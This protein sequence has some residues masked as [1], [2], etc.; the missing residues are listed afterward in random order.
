MLDWLDGVEVKWFAWAAEH[1][2]TSI[3][4]K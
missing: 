3:Y 1:P 2:K 4:G